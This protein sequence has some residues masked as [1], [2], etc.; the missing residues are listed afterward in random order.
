VQI[1]LQYTKVFHPELIARY[2]KRQK[3]AYKSLMQVIQNVAYE[4]VLW[5]R[6]PITSK[7]TSTTK[8]NKR[9]E[10][11]KMFWVK[12]GHIIGK[13]VINIDESDIWYN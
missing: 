5:Q 10:F 4:H 2:S 8:F 11:N 3:K 1:V 9:Q 12:Y 6:K 13:D 7:L